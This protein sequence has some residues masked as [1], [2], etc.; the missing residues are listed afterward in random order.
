M[1]INKLVLISRK[2]VA[3]LGAWLVVSS[4]LVGS[5]YA[6]PTTVTLTDN[7]S[8]A[9]IDLG[10]SAG[11]NS[12]TVNGQNQLN[13]QWFWYRT[14]GGLA[15]PINSIGGLSYQV[16]GNNVLDAIYQ[17]SQ[18]SVEIM[19]TLTGGGVNSGSADI[20]EQIMA[21]NLSGSAFDL[22][23]YQYSNFNLLGAANDNVQIFGSLG[24]YNYVR[25]WN[26]ATA[27]QEAVTAPS[28]FY[29]EAALVNQTLNEFA[30]T[31]GLTLNGNLTSGP[32]NATWALQWTQTLAANGGEFDLT[33]DKSL[34]IS[35]VP[36]PTTTA[37]AVLG[38]LSLAAWT[39]RRRTSA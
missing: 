29:A 34:S 27:I 4:L 10:S 1:S 5:V 3:A 39:M 26:G 6:S 14:D 31:S 16:I 24:N 33:K 20:T 2:R 38:G 28:A 23:F 35:V 30:T 17:N 12:W 8:T 19:Y 32:G 25:Q 7:G 15:Q 21:V 11:M 18:L 22:N 37:L 9:T 36:E 13:Q